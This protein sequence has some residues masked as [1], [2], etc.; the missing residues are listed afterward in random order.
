MATYM[1]GRFPFL[2]IAA[3][4]RRR[5]QR[6]AF[7]GLGPPGEEEL[8]DLAA[9][10][11]A[12]PER[13]YQY[14]AC[15]ELRRHVAVLS[16]PALPAVERL[17]VT[18]PWWDTVDALAAHVVGRLVR[19]DPGLAAVM[20]RWIDGDDVWLARTAVLHQLTWRDRTDAARLFAYCERRA[21]DREFCIRKAIGWALR[22]YARTDPE[23][24]RAFVAAHEATL[25]P[26]SI[27]EATRHL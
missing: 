26:L 27:R 20:D 11:W 21:A 7:D 10:L 3:D 18:K 6:A 2:G 16:S 4:E 17:V 25:S 19:R 9:A 8:L 5:L 23:A 24:V 12:E 22:Q 1:K 14:A 13:E 15:D